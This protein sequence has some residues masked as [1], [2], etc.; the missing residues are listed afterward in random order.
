MPAT[1]LIGMNSPMRHFAKT[2]AASA[3]GWDADTAA[4]VGAPLS[5][6]P[7]GASDA[8]GGFVGD[9]V[10]FGGSVTTA[11]A[12]TQPTRAVVRTE[13]ATSL[14]MASQAQRTATLAV[15]TLTARSQVPSLSRCGE[16]TIGGCPP[17]EPIDRPCPTCGLPA[18]SDAEWASR[19]AA[20][21]VQAGDGD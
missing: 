8:T 20:Q 4:R 3:R 18:S 10:E 15:R 1:S 14:S 2:S 19:W 16:V 21:P 17:D 9:V 11:P 13:S 5:G 12:E 6:V 7:T